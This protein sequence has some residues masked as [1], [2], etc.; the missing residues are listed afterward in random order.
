MKRHKITFDVDNNRI[1]QEI[2]FD[3]KDG[4]GVKRVLKSLIRLYLANLC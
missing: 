3:A 1:Y 4:T 2:T